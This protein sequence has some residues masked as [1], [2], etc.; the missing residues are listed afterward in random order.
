MLILRSPTV[1]V[2]YTYIGL[3]LWYLWSSLL[4]IIYELLW[5]FWS[6]LLHSCK[7]FLFPCF[8]LLNFCLVAEFYWW[9]FYCLWSVIYWLN[10]PSV[11][12]SLDFRLYVVINLSLA[13]QLTL[14]TYFIHTF[15]LLF[16]LLRLRL[17]TL[18]THLYTHTSHSCTVIS[19]LCLFSVL[20]GGPSQVIPCIFYFKNAD[21]GTLSIDIVV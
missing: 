20:H 12:N 15:T 6:S 7:L 1:V 16:Y 3:Y 8:L 13:L 18:Y 11:V 19:Y 2:S 10:Q 4:D 21:L 9:R 14:Y 17:L 5:Y